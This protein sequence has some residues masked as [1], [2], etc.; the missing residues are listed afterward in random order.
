MFI[1]ISIPTIII[2]VILIL[3]YHSINLVNSRTTSSNNNNN[4]CCKCF[5]FAKLDKCDKCNKRKVALHGMPQL[6]GHN[7][8]SLRFHSVRSND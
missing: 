1:S 4:C 2:I 6:G 8:R 7:D 3:K 5:C